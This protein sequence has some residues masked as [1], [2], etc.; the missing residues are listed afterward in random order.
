MERDVGSAIIGI[1]KPATVYV[2]LCPS[3]LQSF[4][5]AIIVIAGGNVRMDRMA[6]MEA[7]VRVVDAG[8]NA[9]PRSCRKHPPYPSSDGFSDG[10]IKSVRGKPLG[11]NS[12]RNPD[13]GI[14][15]TQNR[16]VPSLLRANP[17]RD[18][19]LLSTQKYH[20]DRAEADHDPHAKARDHQICRQ[21]EPARA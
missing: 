21:S 19:V 9:E 17:R 20:Y 5:W 13:Y 18:N 14:D 10:P 2:S 15:E 8:S 7:F 6:A 3:G 12:N 1:D 11:Q 4:C 16:L